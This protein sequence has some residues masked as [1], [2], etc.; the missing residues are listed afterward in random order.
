VKFQ[1][2]GCHVHYRR[3]VDGT[4][5][6]AADG[7]AQYVARMTA[8]DVIQA[9]QLAPHPEGGWYRE[10]YRSTDCVQ[11]GEQARS[12]TTAIYYLLEPQ[13]LSRW[14][15]VDADEIWHFYGGAP[16]ELLAYDPGSRQLE[17]HV[18][19]SSLSEARPVGVIPAG[20]WQAARSLAE[21]PGDY[22]LAGCTVSPGFEFSGF[23]FVADLTDHRA[24]FAGEL[25]RYTALL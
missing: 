6:V 5:H 2:P 3:G 10:I 7:C 13:Q 4:F 12:A 20:T 22:S 23:R 19:H 14:H 18:L 24:H 9:L 11:R 17:R 15:V 25:S 16:L 1:R 21:Q 8:K